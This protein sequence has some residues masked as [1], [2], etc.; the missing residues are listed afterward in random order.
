MTK[1]SIAIKVLLVNS[2]ED[3]GKYSAFMGEEEL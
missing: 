1:Y 2:F 3:I